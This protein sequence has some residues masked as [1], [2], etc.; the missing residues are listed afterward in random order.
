MSL[1][2]VW[3]GLLEYAKTQHVTLHWSRVMVAAFGL[4]VAFIATVTATLLQVI[5]VRSRRKPPISRSLNDA[6]AGPAERNDPAL[7]GVK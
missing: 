2:L 4:L 1:A 6:I 5:K 3:P 7:S